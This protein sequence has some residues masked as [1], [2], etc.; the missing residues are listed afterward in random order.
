MFY[1]NCVCYGEYNNIVL[2]NKCHRSY[3]Y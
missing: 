2:W 3:I 1:V